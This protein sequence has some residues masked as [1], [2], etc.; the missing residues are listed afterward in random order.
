[1][2]VS[3]ACPEGYDPDQ[4]VLDF[5]KDYKDFHLYRTPQE[6]AKDA[7]V[8]ITDVWASMG[9]EGEAEQR[10]KAFD[11]YQ[12]NGE[13]MGAGKEGRHGPALACRRTGARRLPPTSL[14]STPRKSLKRR[15]TVCTLRKRFW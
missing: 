10:K 12:I 11:G 8:V 13:L 6:A 14:N 1:M 3:V 7:D 15:K 2:G 9:Q 5:A 4:Q